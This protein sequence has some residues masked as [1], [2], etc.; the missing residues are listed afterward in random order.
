MTD[1]EKISQLKYQLIELNEHGLGDSDSELVKFCCQKELNKLEKSMEN[2]SYSE[3]LT[4]L[5]KNSENRVQYYK[6]TLEDAYKNK[7][8]DDVLKREM[9]WFKSLLRELKNREEIDLKK[10]V[11]EKTYYNQGLNPPYLYNWK[12][13]KTI[14]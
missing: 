3:F 6:K 9:E 10:L 5:I 7:V 8:D 4:T 1:A 12:K 14:A 11:E 2:L 13:Q